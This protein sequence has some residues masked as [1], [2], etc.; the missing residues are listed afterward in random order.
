MLETLGGL[1][2]EVQRRRISLEILGE[3]LLLVI[4]GSFFVYLFVESLRWPLGAALMPRIAVVIGFP[5]LIIRVITLLRR[6][7][8]QQG[9]IMDMGFSIGIDPKG[10]AKRFVRISSFILGLYLAIWIFGFHIAL[11]L[12]MFFY[13]FVYGKVGWIGSIAVALSFLALIV[14]VYDAVLHVS[15][16]EPLILRIWQ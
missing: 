11:P 2:G 7:V 8:T 1:S 15:W 12:G 4:V 14:G 16:H 6:T 5:F 10:E 13:L 3:I 9:Q